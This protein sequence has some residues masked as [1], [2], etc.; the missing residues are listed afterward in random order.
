MLIDYFVAILLLKTI[1]FILTGLPLI[2]SKIFRFSKFI[3]S[4]LKV[5]IFGSIFSLKLSLRLETVL[6]SIKTLKRYCKATLNMF[7]Q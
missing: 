2:F 1:L 3:L 4:F 7:F 6:N 5:L